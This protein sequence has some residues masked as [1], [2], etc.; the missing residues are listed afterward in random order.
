MAVQLKKLPW[1]VFIFIVDFCT[2]I[3]LDKKAKT[4]RK[5]RNRGHCY[6][7]VT[8]MG[9]FLQQVLLYVGDINFCSA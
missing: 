7:L 9:S 8:M 6:S 4:C 3:Q 2:F 1:A 5:K